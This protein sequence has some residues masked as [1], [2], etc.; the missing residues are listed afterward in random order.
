MAFCIPGTSIAVDAPIMLVINGKKVELGDC[1][2][3][4]V[5]ASLRERP[6]PEGRWQEFKHTA[7]KF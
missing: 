6:S 5:V 1:L 7:L 4:A 3:A 2:S